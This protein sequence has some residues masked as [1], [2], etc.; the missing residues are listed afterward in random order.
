MRIAALHD[1][2]ANAHYRVQVPMLAL[3]AR[4]HTVEPFTDTGTRRPPWD[5]VHVHRIAYAPQLEM[6]RRMREQGVA[7]VF[8]IDDDL[9][10]LARHVLRGFTARKRRRAHREAYEGSIL[11]ARVASLLTT[12]SDTIADVYRGHGVERVAVIENYVAPS[13]RANGRTRHAGLVIGCVA[14]R[15][16]AED[17]KRLRIG[18]T[19][20]HVLERH[21]HVR[22]VTV[23]VDLQLRHPR[24]SY[25]IWVPVEQ[26]VEHGRSFDIGFAPLVDN[27]FN[28]ARSTVKLKEYAASGVPWLAS[29]V[30]PY[31]GMGAR[32]GGEL[33]EDGA[34]GDAFLRLV[35]DFAHRREL[36]VNARRWAAE[37]SLAVA[38]Q[39]WEAAYLRALG[40]TPNR[41]GRQ[42]RR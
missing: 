19:L 28:R 24:Y 12:P 18:Q 4:G 42:R 29:P 25:R 41:A 31:V 9:D 39:R 6:A 36:A 5:V 35:D 13:A 32:E 22:V 14:A 16:H 34:W 3:S 37:Q 23:G 10:A 15:E 1:D 40:R 20:L 8:D 21:E 27:E 38:G 2:S 30:G 33:V 7:V 11:L 26:L 17:F